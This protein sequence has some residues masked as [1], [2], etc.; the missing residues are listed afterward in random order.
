MN[1]LPPKEWHEKRNCVNFLYLMYLFYASM[2][3][4]VVHIPITVNDE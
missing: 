4:M 2:S 3:D 1:A